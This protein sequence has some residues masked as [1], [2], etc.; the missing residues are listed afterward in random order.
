MKKLAVAIA[1]TFILTSTPTLADY[2]IGAKGGK[3]W[4][5]QACTSAYECDKESA[6]V[7]AFVGY[8]LGDFLSIETGFD[9]L[10]RFTAAGLDKKAGMAVTLAPKLNVPLTDDVNLYGK[11]GG[12]FVLYDKQEDFSYLGAV[13]LEFLTDENMAVRLEYQHI[14]D[15]NNGVFRASGNAATVAFVYKFGGNEKPPA[16]VIVTEKPQVTPPVKPIIT[17]ETFKTQK[18]NSNSFKLNSS[19][20][21]EQS[22]DSL[23][24]LVR[25]LNAYPQANVQITGHT[26]STGSASYNQVVSER[27]AMSVADELVKKGVDASRILIDGQGEHSPIASNSTK[28]G[29][30]QNRRVEIIIPEFNYETSI[31]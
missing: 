14:S 6:T 31:K 13:G 2:Y 23:T 17:T 12:A 28:E 16:P 26:D 22:K 19:E 27:R 7:G 3:S 8:E 5:N 20:L 9:Y 18:L 10:G 4:L 21:T 25:I 30:E 11:F 24:P 1:T 15:I 29:R